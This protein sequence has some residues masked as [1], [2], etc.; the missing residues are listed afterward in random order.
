LP[1]EAPLFGLLLFLF[2]AVTCAKTTFLDE[3][4]HHTHVC[5]YTGDLLTVKHGS[6]NRV[7]SPG[8]QIFP[9]KASKPGESTLVLSYF[10]PFEKN[11]PPAKTFRLT[12]TVESRRPSAPSIPVKPWRSRRKPALLDLSF[13]GAA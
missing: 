9:F 3:A 1:L 7:G 2:L 12:L 5:L 13:S 6:P 4:D 11:T 10:R 8:F